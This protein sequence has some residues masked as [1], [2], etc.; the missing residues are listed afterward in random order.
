M[1]D[2]PDRP[3][4]TNLALSRHAAEWG[5]ASLLTGG[6]LLLMA[7]VTLIFNFL[8]WVSGSRVLAPSDMRL[9]FQGAMIALVVLLGLVLASLSCGVIGLYSA[10]TRR[11][12]AGLAAAGIL[13]NVAALVLWLIVGID[14]VAILNAFSR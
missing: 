3:V 1:A 4:E 7:P 5:L 9:A 10:V 6:V 8:F 13:V 11:Q 14:L 12:P 2:V